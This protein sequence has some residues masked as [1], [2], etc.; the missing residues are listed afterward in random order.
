MADATGT[1]RSTGTST[2]T[3]TRPGADDGQGATRALRDLAADPARRPLLVALDF[4][5]VL[6]P[7]VDDPSTSRMLPGSARALRRLA[8]VPDV[9]LALVSGRAMADLHA[10]SAMPPGT[11][12]VGS[13]GGERARVTP[14]GLDR[15]VVRLSDDQTDALARLGA[16]AAAV[17][18]GRD[19]VWVETKP[20]A[21]VVH[22]RLAGR[23]VAATA[24]SEAL[25]LGAELGVGVLHGKSVVE[26]SVLDADK[27][28]A[29][30]AL[31]GELGARAVVYA[32]DDVTDENA[33]RALAE[34]ARGA[35]VLTVKVG[36]GDTAATHRLADPEG[37]AGA[38]TAL[39]DALGAP[40]PA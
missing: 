10:L 15:S 36:D 5:G 32:G 26:M 35:A 28:S 13:H 31:L 18:R 12:L 25:A 6:A 24:E 33:F 30:Q 20:A 40:D 27:G 3:G 39:A 8:E 19:G 34:D 4:D 21:V 2:G 1:A 38:L 9:R 29:L 37:V 23:D 14:L 7:L 17:A 22:T 11:L 16:R